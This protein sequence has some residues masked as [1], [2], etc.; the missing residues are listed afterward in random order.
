[1]KPT[2]EPERFVELFVVVDKA[3][4]NKFPSFTSVYRSINTCIVLV[5][6]E[7]WTTENLMDVDMSS[8][9]TLDHFLIWRQTDLLKRVKH[10]NAQ[11][12]TG[13]DFEGDTVGLANKFAMCTENS[14]GV[15]QDHHRDL[16]GLASTIAHEMG[17]NFG[18]SHDGP[19]CVCGPSLSTNCVMTDNQSFPELF[20]SCS[21]GQLAEFLARARPNCLHKPSL[22]RS[23]ET[24]P[25]CGNALVDPGE[26]CDCGTVQNP[27]C[28]PST[29]RLTFGSLC[30]HGRCCENCKVSQSA[31]S[32]CRRPAGECDLPEYCTGTSEACPDD[33]FVMNGK[34]CS[35]QGPGY[36]YD[37]QCPT[38][39]QHCWRLF[40]EGTK[41]IVY[42]FNFCICC[43]KL[44]ISN[45]CSNLKCGS[46]FCE[47]GGDSITGKRAVFT[48]RYFIK[49]NI[50]VED[51][52]SRNIDM[53]P[54]GTKCGPNKA[55]HSSGIYEII[56]I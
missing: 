46:I 16:I 45:F 52:K 54:N 17:H 39:Q 36:C 18:L 47:E 30:A 32:L 21:E 25:R 10:D 48:V 31:G 29:C 44:T 56:M 55:K 4:V 43:L 23:I 20:S 41:T 6:L 38:H 26:E 51:D 11:F 24:G 49:C 9:I 8:E 37:G 12:V 13:I 35:D 7:I 28:N 5:G 2:A 33:S 50:V 40:G 19:G 15:N 14:G 22:S 27:C 1:S 42:L 3:E 34:P 53:V